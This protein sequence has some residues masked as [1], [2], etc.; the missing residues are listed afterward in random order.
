MELDG[1]RRRSDEV[2][3][4]LDESDGPRTNRDY[5]ELMERQGNLK[6]EIWKREAVCRFLAASR[7]S[8][9]SSVW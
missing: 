3:D 7:S 5:D 8:W 6:E 2:G 4:E 9:Q 1:D